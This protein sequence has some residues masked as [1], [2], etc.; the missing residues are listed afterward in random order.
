MKAIFVLTALVCTCGIQGDIVTLISTNAQPSRVLTIQTNEI[1]TIKEHYAND[2][3]EFLYNIGGTQITHSETCCADP[4][5][6]LTIIQGPATLQIRTTNI[7]SPSSQNDISVAVIELTR[8]TPLVQASNTVV[9]PADSAGPVEIILES[10][11]DLVTWTG[12][13]PGTYGT[14]TTKRFFRLRAAR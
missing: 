12:A 14:A 2:Y 4:L 10:S 3:T 8:E 9:I 13:V 1:A 7:R 11:S 5:P 6:P